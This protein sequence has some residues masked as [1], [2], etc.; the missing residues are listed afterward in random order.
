MSK[1]VRESK[2]CTRRWP[3]LGWQC[4]VL[5]TPIPLVKSRYRSPVA[6]ARYEPLPEA[7]SISLIGRAMPS[8]SLSRA[9]TR[10]DRGA[11]A[12]AAVAAEA[13]AEAEADA[14]VER[15][16]QRMPAAVESLRQQWTPARGS[17]RSVSV[18]EDSM[19][20]VRSNA[21]CWPTSFWRRGIGNTFDRA[22][23]TRTWF[24]VFRRQP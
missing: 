5:V 24:E 8:A 16:L 18:D 21:P 23:C 11:A 17:G 1:T 13:G 14:A 12:A 2:W 15:R 6:D 10:A 20:A 22:L 19:S 9:C 4:P 3:T 7:I